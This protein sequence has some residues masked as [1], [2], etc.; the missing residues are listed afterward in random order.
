MG[1]SILKPYDGGVEITQLM[2]SD[3]GGKLP[4][5][6]K[7]LVSKRQASHGKYVVDFIVKGQEPEQI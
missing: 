2:H 4:D 1:G 7:G 3:G 6:I 5:F